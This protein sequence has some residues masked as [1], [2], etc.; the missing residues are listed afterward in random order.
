M[1]TTRLAVENDADAIKDIFLTTYG[2]QYCHRSFLSSTAVKKLIFADDTV[3]VVAEDTESKRLLGTA[4][5]LEEQGAFTDLVGEFGRLAVHP[6]GRKKGLGNKLMQARIHEVKDRLHVGIAEARVVHPFSTKISLNNGFACC[7]FLPLKH[8]LKQ[9]E[10]TALMIRH[11]GSALSMRRNHPRVIPEVYPLAELVLKYCGL[12]ADAIVE[13]G[14]QAYPPIEDFVSEDWSAR[15][16]ADLLR[17]ERGRI[18]NREIFGPLRLHYGFFKIRATHSHYIL[19]KKGGV[20]VGALGFTV[21]EYDQAVRIFELISLSNEVIHFL[22]SQL[23]K[24]L[25]ELW[26][27][28]Y[29]E[30]DVS[31]YSP[32]MQKTLLEHG[33][34]PTAYIPALVFHDVERLDVI[35]MV[36]LSIP[37]QTERDC[38]LPEI[39]PVAEIVAKGFRSQEIR[40]QM[41]EAFEQTALFTGLNSEQSLQLAALCELLNF[42]A[43]SNIFQE[44][45]KAQYIWIVMQGSVQISK[46]K[47]LSILSAGATIG[48]VALLTDRLHSATAEALSNATLARIEFNELQSLLR[49][50]PDIGL[51]LYKNL[52]EGLS[53]KLSNP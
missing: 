6:E 43:G 42:T 35:R 19:A 14:A 46:D 3:M 23:R 26:E 16:Y 40:P 44:S 20:L 50:R 49:R 31:A 24:K 5:V 21:D 18:K 36:R 39:K 27:I 38:Y 12:G 45:D 34:L 9:R 11:F 17:I 33:F 1:I 8:G 47:P 51:L 53:Q 10:N 37:L 28:L 52:A 2:D 7:G 30:V 32:R 15:G 25:E 41:R 48:E 22:L 13:E 4:S 29:T